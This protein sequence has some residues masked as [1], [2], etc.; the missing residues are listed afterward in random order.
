MRDGSADVKVVSLNIYTMYF[1]WPH[2]LTVELPFVTA[3]QI[4]VVRI[5]SPN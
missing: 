1:P 2:L 5:V 4:V 3:N